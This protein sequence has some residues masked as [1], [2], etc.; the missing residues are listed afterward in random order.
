VAEALARVLARQQLLL[1]LDNCEHVIGAV[2]ELCAALLPA[3]DELRVLATSR[4]PL[5]VPG[6]ALYRLAPLALPG[7]DEL[8]EAAAGCDAVAL[9]A[10]R[11]R[12]ADMHFTLDQQTAP[13]VARTSTR[14]PPERHA[15]PVPRTSRRS[16]RI[17]PAPAPRQI[18]PAARI[19]RSAVGRASASAR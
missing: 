4:E 8:A 14:T 6:E 13:A 11:A 3:A 15:M 18:S 9:F 5:R 10:D 19:R 7:P 2:A 16:P 12:Q 17:S 1:V